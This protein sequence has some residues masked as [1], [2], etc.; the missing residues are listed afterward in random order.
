[1]LTLVTLGFSIDVYSQS[2]SKNDLTYLFTRLPK[3]LLEDSVK[4][5]YLT[6]EI[7][8]VQN[9]F[10][11]NTFINAVEKE[12]WMN[13][14]KKTTNKGL[15]IKINLKKL[16][17]YR[18][19]AQNSSDANK[20]ANQIFFK[21][22]IKYEVLMPKTKETV[23]RWSMGDN[24]TSYFTEWIASVP[25]LDNQYQN[26]INGGMILRKEK[27]LQQNA[28]FLGVQIRSF[29]DYTYMRG[30]PT[31]MSVKKHKNH[32]YIDL[33]GAIASAKEVFATTNMKEPEFSEEAKIRL[34]KECISVWEKALQEFDPKDKKARINKKI[35]EAI[36]Q[37][38]YILHSEMMNFDL[39]DKCKQ[40]AD[41]KFKNSIGKKWIE[42][43]EDAR[44]RY[45]IH[46]PE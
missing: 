43:A 11:R 23:L 25:G 2:L 20:V 16:D 18:K 7:D 19:T 42:Q 46:H 27:Q 6:I 37:N 4:S 31:F 9:D 39:A 22:P 40:E 8:S 15:E 33:N 28:K 26:E 34:T 30:E 14:F 17:V 41:S 21:Y 10:I 1:M 44:E 38:L 29:L 12:V 24:Y 5:Y 13:G 3:I 35:A 36:Y 45:F 32:Q